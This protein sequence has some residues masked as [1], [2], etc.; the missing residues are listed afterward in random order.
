MI[1]LAGGTKASV[2]K[3]GVSISRNGTTIEDGLSIESQYPISSGDIINVEEEFGVSEESAFYVY[4]HGE[5]KRPG[6]YQFRRGLTV[7][8]AV[9]LAG[10]FTLRASRK[11]ITVSRIVNDEE[12]PIKLKKAKLYLPVHP[13]DVIDVGASWL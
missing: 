13:G 5:V 3:N 4:L 9:V 2:K 11:K 8:K 6:E 1:A 12:A 7:E 10:G